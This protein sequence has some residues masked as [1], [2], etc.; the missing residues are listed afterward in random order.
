MK[1]NGYHTYYSSLGQ[2]RTLTQKQA[3]EMKKG[4]CRSTYRSVSADAHHS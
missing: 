3:L 1:S 2:Q 4:T